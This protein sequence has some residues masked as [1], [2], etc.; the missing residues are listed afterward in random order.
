[1]FDLTKIKK[2]NICI[3]GLM[4]SGKS[5]IARDLSKHLNVKFYDSDQEIELKTKKKITTIFQ[6][7]GEAY[8]RDL[9]E[10]NNLKFLKGKRKIIAL[11]GGGFINKNIGGDFRDN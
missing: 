10:K 7:E 1:M 5:L 6:E 2:K 3:I 8:F 11:G 4:G 9:E